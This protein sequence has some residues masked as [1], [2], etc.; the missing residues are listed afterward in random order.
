MEAT[1]EYNGDHND[2]DG[3]YRNDDDDI[4]YEYFANGKFRDIYL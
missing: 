3:D 4:A 1:D 2:D